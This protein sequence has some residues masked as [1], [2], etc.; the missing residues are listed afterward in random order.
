MRILHK[1][2]GKIATKL[3]VEVNVMYLKYEQYEEIMKI[4]KAAK[5]IRLLNV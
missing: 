1:I 4:K 5:S 2:S 3:L